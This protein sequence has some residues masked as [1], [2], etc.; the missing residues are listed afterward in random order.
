MTRADGS[1]MAP[2][3]YHDSPSAVKFWRDGLFFRDSWFGLHVEREKRVP[4]RCV[5]ALAQQKG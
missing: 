3:L 1:P 5:K 4:N 2:S